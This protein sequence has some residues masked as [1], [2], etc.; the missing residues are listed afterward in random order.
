MVRIISAAAVAAVLAGAV[1]AQVPIP[2]LVGK[3]GSMD[4]NRSRL[5]LVRAISSTAENML[6]INAAS[7]PSLAQVVDTATGGL[8]AAGQGIRGVADSALA[9][10]DIP[11]NSNMVI[12]QGILTTY[13][14]LKGV[15]SA[16]PG[17]TASKQTIITAIKAGKAVLEKCGAG[18]GGPAPPAPAEIQ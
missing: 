7:D 18:V 1:S 5:Q 6:K 9:T 17:V 14:A 11:G 8:S 12:G 2:V 10:G 15:Q 16:D 3:L 4:C 13:N